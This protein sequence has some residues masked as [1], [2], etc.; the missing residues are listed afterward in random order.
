MRTRPSSRISAGRVARQ[1]TARQHG[2]VLLLEQ[3]ARKGFI[4][5]D[6]RPQVEAPGRDRGVVLQGRRDDRR[7]ARELLAVQARFSITWASSFQAG[8]LASCVCSGTAQP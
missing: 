2:D 7:H 6:A 1:V 3:S 8:M 5:P 4:V